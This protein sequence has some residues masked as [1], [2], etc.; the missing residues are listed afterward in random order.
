VVP[1]TWLGGTLVSPQKKT[2]TFGTPWAT[3]TMDVAQAG[4]VKFDTSMIEQP[5]GSESWI[6]V[7]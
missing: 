6:V 5:T 4:I 1:K 7:P 3:M 2:W